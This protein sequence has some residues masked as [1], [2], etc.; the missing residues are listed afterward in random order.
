[1]PKQNPYLI[2]NKKPF[3]TVYELKNYEIKTSKLS[4]VARAKVINKSGSNY[5]SE[6]GKEGY[7][8]MPFFDNSDNS[9][10]LIVARTQEIISELR[11]NYP[12]VVQLLNHNREGTVAFLKAN[13]ALFTHDLVHD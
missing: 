1:M 13:G 6:R 12:T 7:G 5:V 8:P 9:S 11:R 2:E 3:E 4:P 10:A